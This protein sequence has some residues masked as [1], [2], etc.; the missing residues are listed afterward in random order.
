MV[1]SG[2]LRLDLKPDL[3]VLAFTTAV[4]LLTGI[5]FGMA[6][7][8]QASRLDLV[9]A[10]KDQG[11]GGMGGHGRQYV[12]RTL[13]V[14]QIALSLMLLIGAGLLIRSL[15][16][17]RNIDLGFRPA[18]VYIFDLAHNPP[19]REPEALALV[20]RQTQDRV[21]QIPGIES[22]SLSGLL[23]FSPS[24]IGAPLKIRGYTPGDGEKVSARFN[25]VSS[26]YFETVG[27]T[28]VTGRGIEDRDTQDGP[29]VAVINESMARRYFPEMV[30]TP[31]NALG[32][33]IEIDAGAMKGKLIEI[34]GVVRD[35]KYNNLR[36]D[37]KPMFYMP[38]E[39]L[40]RT[41]RSLEVRTKEPL[42]TIAEPVRRALLEVSTDVMIRRVIPLSDQ[43]DRTLAGERL[44]TSLSVVFGLL[45]LLLA[46]IGLYGVISYSVT[47]RTREIGIRMALGA[48]ERGVVRLVLRQGL[49]VVL[50][51]VAA[52][53]ALVV[54]ATR[55]ISSFLYGLSPLDPI[56]IVLA[57]LMLGLV[58]LLA[59]YLPAQRA[60][61][62]NPI[63]ALRQ[64]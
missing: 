56:T 32:R 42:T 34:V 47:Q 18:Q 11:F 6:P 62:V 35:A 12:G 10:I 23:I 41:L 44:I 59:C 58:A 1:D 9:S 5:A 17:L 16:N 61:R 20:A 52:G 4:M 3:R 14:L 45:A 33:T 29:Y 37:V 40:P 25:S 50:V 53:L 13:I 55:L 26:G 28:L 54:I 38:I 48:S 15:Y 36:A 7:A 2:S 8:L 22:S 63:L 39:Q 30:G 57:L 46:S 51:G 64:E 60:A 24:D 21:R 27:M 31:N 43:V 19:N 49:T